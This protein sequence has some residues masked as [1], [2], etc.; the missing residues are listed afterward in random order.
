MIQRTQT[1]DE[2][3]TN[4]GEVAASSAVKKHLKGE[5]RKAIGHVAVVRDWRHTKN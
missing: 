3:N 2:A 1:K 5:G 4:D